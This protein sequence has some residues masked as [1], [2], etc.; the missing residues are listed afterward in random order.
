MNDQQKKLLDKWLDIISYAAH[1]KHNYVSI[2]TE[3][4]FLLLDCLD[5]LNHHD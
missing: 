4:L 5:K 1:Y 3:E 2:P